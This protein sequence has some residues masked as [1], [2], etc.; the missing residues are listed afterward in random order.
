MTQVIGQIL[1]MSGLLIELIGVWAVFTGSGDNEARRISLPGGQTA[2]IGWLVVGLG[3]AIWL[4]GRILVSVSAPRRRRFVK[5]YDDDVAWSGQVGDHLGKPGQ[6]DEP[7]DSHP[8][9]EE[10]KP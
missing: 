2:P 6:L 9:I 5:T 7:A 4:T 10:V 8:P 3:F 1:R